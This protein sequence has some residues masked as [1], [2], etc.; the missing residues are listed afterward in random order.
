MTTTE[1][2]REAV[3]CIFDCLNGEASISDDDRKALLAERRHLLESKGSR[4]AFESLGRMVEILDAPEYLESIFDAES[5]WKSVLM[6]YM[7]VAKEV[8]VKRDES[9]S[10]NGL[11]HER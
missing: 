1:D 4:E 3:D 5:L 9:V 11:S 6:A 8:D 10:G 7:A 2:I